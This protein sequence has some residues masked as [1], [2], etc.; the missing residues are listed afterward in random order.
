MKNDYYTT[1]SVTSMLRDLKWQPLAERKR[2]QRLC[3]LF[4]IISSLVA[5]PTEPHI[6]FNPRPSRNKNFKSLCVHSC[7]SDIFKNH[8]FRAL[9]LIGTLYRNL[10][11]CVNLQKHSGQPFHRLLTNGFKCAQPTLEIIAHIDESPPVTIQ[12]QTDTGQDQ[13]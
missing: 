6:A 7:Y 1:S 9:F 12:I 10:Q 4:K 5:I 3:L 11:Y 2:D 8:S 13:E